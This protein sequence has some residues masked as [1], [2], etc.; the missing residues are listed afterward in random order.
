MIALAGNDPPRARP[1]SDRHC[2]STCCACRRSF[3][4][5]PSSSS[6]DRYLGI[7]PSSLALLFVAR[8]GHQTSVS[9]WRRAHHA[10]AEGAWVFCIVRSSDFRKD[11]RQALRSS[12][13]S[14][15]READRG[16]PVDL[17]AVLAH[18]VRMAAASRCL[19]EQ[20]CEA[21]NS[22][23]RAGSRCATA[24]A[25]GVVL[26]LFISRAFALRRSSPGL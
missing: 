16:H 9:G 15:L 10:P 26:T 13:F 5:L 17:P 24:R 20:Q 22:G 1:C 2:F 3:R 8:S 21:S 7:G 23:F 19:I 11:R 6:G 4:A 18:L 25:F 14:R 12:R